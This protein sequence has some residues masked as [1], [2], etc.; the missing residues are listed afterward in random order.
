[1]KNKDVSAM[2]IAL[3][4]QILIPYGAFADDEMSY[5][6]WE[7]YYGDP[8]YVIDDETQ[9]L[10]DELFGNNL[11]PNSFDQTPSQFFSV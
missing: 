4:T 2:F 7:E 1:M 11:I 10:Y 8:S 3:F 9:K 6:D 5:W